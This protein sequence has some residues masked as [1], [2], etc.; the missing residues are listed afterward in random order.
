MTPVCIIRQRNSPLIIHGIK[1]G[2]RPAASRRGHFPDQ[3]PR[4]AACRSPYFI[5]Y[6]LCPLLDEANDRLDP[7]SGV[8]LFHR[9]LVFVPL[10]VHLHHF[11]AE[12]VRCDVFFL[13]HGGIALLLK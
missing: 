7:A 3:S 6:S 13:Q 9:P 5:L 8:A 4:E 1:Q 12:S 10:F 11:F 2:L